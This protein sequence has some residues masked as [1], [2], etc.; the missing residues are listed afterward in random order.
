MCCV[1]S[2]HFWALQAITEA[3]EEKGA[4][5]QPGKYR[6]PSRAKSP[7]EIHWLIGLGSVHGLDVSVLLLAQ[8]Q[9]EQ[10]LSVL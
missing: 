3:F 2:G 5:S 1:F 10:V 6:V 4:W 9:G 8:S 7:S